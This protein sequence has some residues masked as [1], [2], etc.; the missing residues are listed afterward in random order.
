MLVY[1]ADETGFSICRPPALGEHDLITV[2]GSLPG[3][4]PGE[5]LSLEG[6]WLNHPKYGL[7]FQVSR[8]TSQVPATA[9]G[10]KRYLS[11]NL[12]K[13]IG[14]VVAGRIVHRFGDESLEVIEE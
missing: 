1:N 2:V 8:H 6:R 11:S 10:M 13:G 12:V 3:I 5:R 14:Q 7:R 9:N 4:Q